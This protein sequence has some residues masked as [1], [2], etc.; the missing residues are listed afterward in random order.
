MYN[1]DSFRAQLKSI[2]KTRRKFKI[3]VAGQKMFMISFE[4][5]DDL[6]MIME[7][8]PCLFRRQLV[9]FERLKSPIERINIQLILSLFWL[10]IGPCPLECDKKDLIGSTFGGVI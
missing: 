9:I 6:E 10:K 3:Q 5:K 4:N 2:W 1:L 7:R 8:Q